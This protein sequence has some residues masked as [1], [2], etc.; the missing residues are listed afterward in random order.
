MGRSGRLFLLLRP[1]ALLFVANLVATFVASVMDGATFVLLIPFLRTLF[2]LDPL[3]VAGGSAVERLLAV[4]VGPLFAAGSPGAALR[5][6]VLVL[7]AAMVIK[8]VLAYL[9]SVSSVAIQENV[10]RD[11]RVRLFGHLQTLALDFF[12]RTRGGQL[13]S[14]VIN[15]TDAVKTVVTAA[16][17]SLVQNVSLIVVYVAILVGLSWQLTLVALVCAPL[18]VLIVRPMVGR[19]RWRSREQADQ[20][21]ELTSLV[22]ELVGSIKLVRAYVA[23]AFEADRFRALANRYRKGVLRAQRYALLTSPVSEVF[24]GAV[25][26]LIFAVGTRLALGQAA[27]LQPLQPEVLI[28]FIAVALRLMSPVKSVANYPTTMA[29]ALAAADRVFEVLDLASE[30]GDRPGEVPARFEQRI[31]YRGVSFSYNGQAPVLEGLDF[32]VRRGQV[33]AVVGPSGAGKTTLVDLLPRFYEPKRG[34]ILM[35]GVPITRFTRTSLRGLMGIVSQE[36]IL[37]NDTVLANVSYGRSDFTLEQVQ[38]A[39]RA[40]NAHDFVSQ[41][42]EGYHTLLGERGTRVSGGE[43]QRI[44][45]ARALLRDPPILILDEATS[46]LDMESERL[47]QEAI[48][49]LMAHRTTFVIAH[50]LATV[51]HADLIVVLAGFT[52]VRN[53]VRLDYPIV[54]AIRSILDICDEVVVNVGRSD[55]ETR[56]LV[57]GIGDPRVRILD[58]VWDFS[59]GG[60]TLSF[61]TNRAMA[62]CGGT[63]GIYIQADE[64]LPESG[65]ALIGAALRRC[66]GEPLVEGLLVDYLHFYGDF[67]TIATD[68]HWYRREVRV[69]RLGGE[70][71]SYQDAQGFRVGAGDRRVRARATGA[72]MFHYGWARPPQSLHRKVIAAQEIFRS[73]EHTSELQS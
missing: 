30:E 26:V 73:E 60:G 2:G 50:R 42:P 65:A 32:E 27:V 19:V 43:R 40:A 72:Q 28:A 18:L 51:Q 22:S 24:A 62:A 48:D 11:L 10:V 8:N 71:R 57:A 5:N 34:A 14:R 7:V 70:I 23:E 38:A 21:G 16:L 29:G 63:W 44:A 41:L 61:E 56:D 9:A 66:D 46:A 25:I 45:I 69:V 59:R 37:L 52:I 67:W 49:R 3:N 39:A 4:V 58:S 13:L 20:R 17:A 6:V 1:Y 12:Q 35:D 64:V 54:P 68:R 55:D 53:A 15:D 47:V 31:E 33:V 36:T